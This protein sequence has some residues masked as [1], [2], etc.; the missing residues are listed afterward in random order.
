MKRIFR[1]VKDASDD[2]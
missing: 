1:K 2:P